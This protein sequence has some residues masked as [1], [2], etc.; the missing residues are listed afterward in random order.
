MNDDKVLAELQFE[1]YHIRRIWDEETQEWWYAVVDVIE[2][3]TSRGRFG[4]QVKNTS[5]QR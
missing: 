4:I 5:Y 2:A 3:L 1:K